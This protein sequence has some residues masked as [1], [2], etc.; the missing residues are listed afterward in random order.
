MDWWTDFFTNA[1][2]RMQAGGYPPERT[3]AECDRIE[4]IL[5][6]AKG[7]RVL[8]IPC[9]IGRH[10][11]ELAKRGYR[12][13]GVDFQGDFIEEAK[14]SAASAGVGPEFVVSDM[15]NFSSPEPFDAAFCYF[16][17]F[18]YFSEEDDRRFLHGVAGSLRPGGAF[19]LEGHIQETLLPIFRPRDWNWAGP[20]SARVLVA[21]ER[22]WDMDTGRVEVTWRLWDGDRSTTH[23]SSIRIYGFREVRDLFLSSGFSRVEFRDSMTGDLFRM[24]SARASMVAVRA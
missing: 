24:G 14:E 9:G 12:M 20:E 13:T 15:R 8:D 19:L 5:A 23:S 10:S 2:P 1:W 11:V 4:R 22:E 17:S 16:G 6:L 18:G 3:L 7:A 21:E